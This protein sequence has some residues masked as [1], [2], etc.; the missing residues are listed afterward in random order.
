[1]WNGK[2][3]RGSVPSSCSLGEFK[4]RIYSL[5]WCERI[6]LEILT[7]RFCDQNSDHRRKVQY[8]NG[9]Y[10]SSGKN[11]IKLLRLFNVIH[12][13]WKINPVFIIICSI[14]KLMITHDPTGNIPSQLRVGTNMYDSKV[15][16]DPF[17]AVK[18]W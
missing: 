4:W 6:Y 1:M 12:F 18:E 14:I 9:H 13:Y 16:L 10:T 17:S 11:S 15:T 5:I 8:T 7:T 2:D 3:R